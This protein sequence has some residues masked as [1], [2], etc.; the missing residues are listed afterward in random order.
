MNCLMCRFRAGGKLLRLLRLELSVVHFYIILGIVAIVIADM[1]LTV[2]LS[3]A[4]NA[5]NEPHILALFIKIQDLVE[6][7]CI[8]CYF[9]YWVW[10]ICFHPG[11]F[12][13][14]RSCFCAYPCKFGTCIW[15]FS[16]WKFKIVYGITMTHMLMIQI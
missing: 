13:I 15:Y 6:N 5:R 3:L 4:R 1:E 16:D 12:L 14:L 9:F 8:G 11:F 10:L 7:V 2:N